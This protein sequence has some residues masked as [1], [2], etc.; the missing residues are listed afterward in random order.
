MI[1]PILRLT[2]SEK[3]S[4]L[5]RKIKEHLESLNDK[6]RRR[7][8]DTALTEDETR[9]IRALIAARKDVLKLDF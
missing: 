6:D 3:N 5:W 2:E 4:Q 7:N 8:D 1:E 9:K